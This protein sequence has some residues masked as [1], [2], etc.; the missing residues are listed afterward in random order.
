MLREIGGVGG[1]ET[2]LSLAINQA[3]VFLGVHSLVKDH[4]K[5][6]VTCSKTYN[7]P[8]ELINYPMEE[9]CVVQILRI[10]LVV[11]REVSCPIQKQSHSHLAQMV[12]ATFVL[13]VYG[14]L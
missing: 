10:D 14:Q 3:K 12:F 11:E 4:G 7:D 8:K 9:L 1:D 2:N 6:F 13:A 5:L